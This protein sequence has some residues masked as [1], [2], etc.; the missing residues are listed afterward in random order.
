MK[1]TLF[2]SIL[3]FLATIKVIASLLGLEQVSAV[4]SMSNLSPAMK[5]FT[6]HKGYET[7]SSTF[8]IEALYQDGL[9]VKKTLTPKL[10]SHLEGAYNRRNVYGALIAYA[11]LLVTNTHTKALYKQMSHRAFCKEE[12][13]L[14][15]LNFKHNNPIKT[16]ILSYTLAPSIKQTFDYPQSIKVS[17]DN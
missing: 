5:V 12:H 3:I 14:K 17:C 11:P 8:H 10:Y 2:A 4:A 7:Y 16:I 1:Y 13:I 9:T 6:A 15:E